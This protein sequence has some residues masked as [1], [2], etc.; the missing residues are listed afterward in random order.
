MKSLTIKL[1]FLLI[2]FIGVYS[3]KK[4]LS[5]DEISNKLMEESGFLTKGEINEEQENNFKSEEKEIYTGGG[6]INPNIFL[7]PKFENN[8]KVNSLVDNHDIMRFSETNPDT[9]NPG[10]SS[11]NP[12]MAVS[13]FIIYRVLI[14]ILLL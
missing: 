10:D 1:T 4:A 12:N 14:E 11:P 7:K 13:F 2:I 8:V 6:F 5:L 3:S 9:V